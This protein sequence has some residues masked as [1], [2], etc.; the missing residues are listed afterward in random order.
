[1]GDPWGDLNALEA[2]FEQQL[3]FFLSDL[4]KTSKHIRMKYAQNHF[5]STFGSAYLNSKKMNLKL[6]KQVTK[7]PR[8]AS[9]PSDIGLMFVQTMK[10]AL[11]LQYI[12]IYHTENETTI[13]A[14][15]EFPLKCLRKYGNFS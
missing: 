9:F 2:T 13:T 14:S 11:I 6:A 4:I 3:P 5:K 7:E 12:K 15:Y 1:M 8:K 10:Y